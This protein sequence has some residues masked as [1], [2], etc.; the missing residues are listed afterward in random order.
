MHKPKNILALLDFSQ[1]TDEVVKTAGDLCKFYDAKCW[2]IHIASPD[3]DF[4]G[5]DVG[6][7][8]IRD[9][10]A[11]VLAEEH[12][13]LQVYKSLLEEREMTCEALLVMG[14][15]YKT[16]EQE[17]H[18]L[19]ADIVVLGSHGRS[20]LYELV[21]GSVCEYLLKHA[22]VPLMIIPSERK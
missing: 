20:M 1:I 22:D 8:Y 15:L 2:L 4:V 16:I 10:R 21:V 9:S 12:H 6:P 17:I 14:P 3:P 11:T 18:K 13:K 5:Y 19:A 7:Q